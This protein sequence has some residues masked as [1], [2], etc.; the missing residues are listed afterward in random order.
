MTRNPIE[1]CTQ[2]NGFMNGFQR[3][4]AEQFIPVLSS[5]CIEF[6]LNFRLKKFK[7][8]QKFEKLYNAEINFCQLAIRYV[9]RRVCNIRNTI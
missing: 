9:Y 3:H 5:F 8:I 1:L 4:F 6:L 2:K 7:I